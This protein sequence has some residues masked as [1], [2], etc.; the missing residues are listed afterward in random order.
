MW[1]WRKRDDFISLGLFNVY[2]FLFKIIL[3]KQIYNET[4]ANKFLMPLQFTHMT[5]DQLF[6]CFAKSR[7]EENITN[8]MTLWWMCGLNT[9][10]MD[11][12][13]MPIIISTRIKNTHN[14]WTQ[15]GI[16]KDKV[17]KLGSLY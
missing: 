3:E 8:E 16:Q 15:V 1:T 4:L 17:S 9:L 10:S 6:W 12:K 2:C 5:N 7:E 13:F 14:T 11:I